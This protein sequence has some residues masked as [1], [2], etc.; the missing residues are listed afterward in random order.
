MQSKFYP[1]KR[2]NASSN[3]SVS[4]VHKH[5]KFQKRDFSIVIRNNEGQF[6]KLIVLYIVFVNQSYKNRKNRRLF[7]LANAGINSYQT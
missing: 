3:Q 2:F 4:Q 5:E 7:P 1:N 6:L